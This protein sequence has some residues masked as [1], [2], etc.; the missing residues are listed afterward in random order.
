MTTTYLRVEAVNIGEVAWDTEQLS[1]NRGG[2]LM[3]LYAIRAVAAKFQDK[4]K[5][6]SQGASI[7]VFEVL[8]D[9]EGIVGQIR[10]FLS[11]D[12]MTIE[13]GKTVI[14]ALPL[15]QATFLVAV[16]SAENGQFQKA[17]ELLIAD[18]KWQQLQGLSFS[19]QWGPSTAAVCEIDEI[20]PAP[21]SSHVPGKID[22]VR[23]SVSSN[24]RRKVGRTIRQQFYRNELGEL[25]S[26]Q[27][28]IF[29]T[30]TEQLSQGAPKAF[31]TLEG[32]IALVYADGNA[33]GAVQKALR[34]PSEIRDWDQSIRGLRRDKFL[35]PLLRCTKNDEAWQFEG[36]STPADGTRRK[37]IRIETLMW[38][39]DEFMMMVPAW[40]GLELAQTLFEHRDEWSFKTKPLTHAV[41]V[42]FAHHN[43]PISRLKSLAEKL[44]EGAK[45]H[46]DHK[47]KN[48]LS[49]LMLESFDHLGSGFENY[50]NRL[51]A[52]NGKP[53]V[54]W[55]NFR[56]TPEKLNALQSLTVLKDFLPRSNLVR[57][58]QLSARNA[59]DHF[60][61]KNSDASRLIQRAYQAVDDRLS[62]V[63][64][65]AKSANKLP[66]TVRMPVKKVSAKEH[67]KVQWMALAEVPWNA[68]EPK[69]SDLAAWAM[70]IEFWDYL[71]D[72]S[73]EVAA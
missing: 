59:V 52:L 56:L 39:G 1:V 3:L 73:W 61:E 63:N 8:K 15:S 60:E 20:R 10:A 14:P 72:R 41:S 48:S 38:G 69:S 19:S 47:F 30:D 23:L 49:W 46:A 57:I 31:G 66:A 55:D 25:E 29:S 34:E 36:E 71:S 4:L 24:D 42:V 13:V 6:I 54:G 32:K 17:N 28:L 35:R 65:S 53:R 70:I 43:A 51:G 64:V 21:I 2:G 12:C 67:W 26:D 5:T 44:V 58:L 50:W 22:P 37:G 7:G 45:Q 40:K 18:I 16:V 9:H 68:K 33:F 62:N 27:N 11:R